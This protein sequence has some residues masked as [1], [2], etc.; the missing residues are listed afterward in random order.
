MFQSPAFRVRCGLNAKAMREKIRVCPACN[1]HNSDCPH[2]GGGGADDD[3]QGLNIIGGVSSSAFKRISNEEF[4]LRRV[5]NVRI[6]EEREAAILIAEDERL[7]RMRLERRIRAME[8]LKEERKIQ[9]QKRQVRWI[10]R[11]VDG[12]VPNG[13]PMN[14]WEKL[15]WAFIH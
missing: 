9:S 4:D 3:R 10:G 11:I 12:S 6:K 15:V 14:W 13:K 5:Q 7:E 8:K 1:G 2:C